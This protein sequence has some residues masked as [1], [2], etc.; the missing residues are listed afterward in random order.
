MLS[1][2]LSF[3]YDGWETNHSSKRNIATKTKT[4]EEKDREEEVPSMGGAGWGDGDEVTW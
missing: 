2:V 1:S 4:L 3:G